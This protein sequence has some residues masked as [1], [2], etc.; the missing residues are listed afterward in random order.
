MFIIF[1]LN[2]KINHVIGR[3]NFF[4]FC[5]HLI[6][7][8]AD[9]FVKKIFIA[10]LSICFNLLTKTLCILSICMAIRLAVVKTFIVFK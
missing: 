10:I 8:N 7:C 6:C 9:I 4:D 3:I 1:L 5:P 2:N